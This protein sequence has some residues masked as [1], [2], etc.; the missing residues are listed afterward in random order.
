MNESEFLK[1]KISKSH[2]LKTRSC[3]RA[4][5]LNGWLEFEVMHP[6]Q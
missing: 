6:M 5:R 4:V 3:F 2:G 1:K